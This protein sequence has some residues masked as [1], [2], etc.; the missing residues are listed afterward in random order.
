MAEVWLTLTAEAQFI[1][2]EGGGPTD[3]KKI[4]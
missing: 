1:L 4:V 2:G 3:R